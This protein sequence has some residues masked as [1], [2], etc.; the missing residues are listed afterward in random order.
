MSRVRV[1][2]SDG[3]EVVVDDISTPVHLTQADLPL[4]L[5]HGLSQ[6]RH[7]WTP[8]VS[9]L[10]GVRVITIDQRCHGDATVAGDGVEIGTDIDVSMTR[11]ATD[12]A[13]VLDAREIDQ[14][15]VVG[16]SWGASVAL[17]AAAQFPLRVRAAA[18]I[19]G[20]LFGPRHLIGRLGDRTT[21]REALRPPPLG[22]LAPELW[23]AIAGGDLSP[24]W[25]P[26]I[27]AALEPAFRFDSS[28][29]AFTRI[30]MD[31]HMA[32]LDAMF[33]YDPAED[34]ARVQCPVWAVICDSRKP[35]GEPDDGDEQADIWESARL[36]AIANLPAPFFVQRWYRALHDV[37]L[38]WPAL[39]AGLLETIAERT[40]A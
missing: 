12:V 20:G 37:P 18:L 17:R 32:V 27:R 2:T 23:E 33:D 16:H 15:I 25:G 4:V 34:V 22:M 36:E 7:F 11:L 6:Q 9:R 26:E 13:E 30:G 14:A 28:G 31:R 19:D 1:R 8:V 29:R 24:Y 5:L 21:V 39:V 3:V 35:V 40:R 10:H 38:Q